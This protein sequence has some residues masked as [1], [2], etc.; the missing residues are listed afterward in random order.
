M[1]RLSSRQRQC[2]KALARQGEWPATSGT[3]GWSHA[4]GA[5]SWAADTREIL[6]AL[7]RLGL[8]VDD[9]TLTVGSAI[10]REGEAIRGVGRT[11]RYVITAAGRAAVK[12]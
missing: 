10:G 3:Y 11:R 6:A 8:A 9:S 1:I 2:L 12:L 5:D 7:V 4:D